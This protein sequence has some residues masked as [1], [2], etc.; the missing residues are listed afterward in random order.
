M[1]S[2]SLSFFSRSLQ[3]FASFWYLTVALKVFWSVYK[4]L[5]LLS[6]VSG[7]QAPRECQILSVSK[8]IVLKL[9]LWATS[10]KTRHWTKAPFFSFL[11]EESF[12]GLC[13]LYCVF[14]GTNSKL[15]SP[16][17][18]SVAPRN[19][20]RAG[21]CMYS[22]AGEKETRPSGSP[23]Q[24][25]RMLDACSNSFTSLGEARGWGFH[26]LVP[27]WSGERLYWVSAC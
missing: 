9:V 21:F 24:T 4:L 2:L 23:P 5:S 26:Q 8:S 12:L 10:G 15:L 7:S 3:T 25:A 1:V 16:L 14:S 22:E 11:T 20:E 18:F 19:A 6:V 13:L 27:Y 17:S